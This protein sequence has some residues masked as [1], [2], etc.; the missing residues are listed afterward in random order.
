M[1]EDTV[2]AAG[3]ENAAVVFSPGEVV[4]YLEV[5]LGIR[6]CERASSAFA[7]TTSRQTVCSMRP[8]ELNEFQTKG[9]T[10]TG[11]PRIVQ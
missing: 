4:V 10:T 11:R 1:V 8:N 7:P 5:E 2:V 6:L 3:E 9:E